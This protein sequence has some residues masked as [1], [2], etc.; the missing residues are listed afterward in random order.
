MKNRSIDVKGI[1]IQFVLIVFSVVL[2]LYL[3][4]RIEDRKNRK[5]SE[6][7]LDKI[8]SEVMDNISLLEE[9]VPYHQEIHQNLVSLSKN[10]TFIEEFQKD[11]FSL[12]EK[13][14]TKSTFMG[15]APANDAW[16]IAKTH[17]LVTSIDYDKLLILSRVYSQQKRTFEP[18]KDMFEIFNSKNVNLK[19]DAKA[20]LELMAYRLHELVAREKQLMYYYEQSKEILGLQNKK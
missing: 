15:R 8:K 18:G 13:L 6:E 10:D 2:G 5:E 16:D 9:Y 14:L 7:L 1:I 11:K 19:K 20:N 3:S 12:M 4:E 17:P